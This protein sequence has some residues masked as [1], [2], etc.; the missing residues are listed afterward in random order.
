MR[1]FVADERFDEIEKELSKLG[2]VI[3]IEKSG[4]NVKRAE[5]KVQCGGESVTM[6]VKTNLRDTLDFLSCNYD[7]AVLKG[8]NQD[9]VLSLDINPSPVESVE[10]A[11]KA[12][13][14]V[15]LKAI[16]EEVKKSPSTSKCGAMGVF[17][18]FVREVSDGKRVVRLEYEKYGDVFEKTLK[19]IESELKKYEGVAEV[20]IHH[21]VGS[22]RPREDIVYVVVMGEHRKDIW[23]PLI[24]SMELV[25]ERLPVWKKEVYED[26]EEWVHDKG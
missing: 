15:S 11:L 7:F 9:E 8:F 3:V 22:L 26:G 14:W 18:G 10:D 6:N 19:E 20:K 23:E 4:E 17:I 24:Q 1:V 5:E 21:R 2:R 12:E 13:E 25:K 16:M